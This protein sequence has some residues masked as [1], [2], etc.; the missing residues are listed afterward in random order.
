MTVMPQ[1]KVVIEVIDVVKTF[2]DRRGQKV[3]VL[4]KVAFEVY[5]GETVV[6]MGGSGCGKSTLL[7]CM[8]GEYACDEGGVR[9]FGR[10]ITAMN[11]FELNEVRKEFGI[12]FQSAALFNSMTVAENVALPLVEHTDLVPSVV[13]IIITMKLE[14]VRMLP[15]RQ[16]LPGQLSGGQKK[17]VGLARATALDPK[18][19]FYDEPSAGL[20]PV[21]AAAIDDLMISLSR[22]LGVTSVVVTHDMASAFRIADR[23]IMLHGGKVLK[24]GRREEFE[25]LRDADADELD[26]FEQRLIR[27]FLLGEGQGPLTD[28]EGISE[29]EKMISTGSG[30]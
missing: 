28:A 24:I 9:L 4:D 17:R 7:N 6:I 12:L 3:R 30:G 11:E 16:K 5:Q 29:Y 21:T 22:K 23:M 15:H 8:I 10:D 14:Q 26:Q 1:G 20:D 27:Q 25:Q 2:A 18:I 19:L 13:D